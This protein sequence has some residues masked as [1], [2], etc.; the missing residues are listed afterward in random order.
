VSAHAVTDM[1]GQFVSALMRKTF[2]LSVIKLT[3]PDAIIGQ[4][5]NAVQM[6]RRY[7]LVLLGESLKDPQTGQDLGRTESDFGNVVITRVDDNLSYG[8]IENAPSLSQTFRPGLLELREEMPGLAK[9][10]LAVDTGPVPVG[11]SVST[12]RPD[13]HGGERVGA[14]K[15]ETTEGDQNW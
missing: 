12:K 10:P 14:H 6:G 13:R 1:T 11:R 8:R 5:G 7:R 2:P 15:A 3:G 9:G 4:G